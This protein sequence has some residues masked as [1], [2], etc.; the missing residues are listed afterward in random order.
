MRVSELRKN[1]LK[2]V[3]KLNKHQLVELWAF[4]SESD[5]STDKSSKQATE[6]LLSITG[7]TKEVTLA[8]KQFKQGKGIDW[9]LVRSDI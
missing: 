7:L 8:K 2:R 1:L 6:E 5:I 4:I 3:E 9:R